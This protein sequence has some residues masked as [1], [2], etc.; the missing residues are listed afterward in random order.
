VIESEKILTFEVHLHKAMVRFSFAIR[1]G[2]CR[3]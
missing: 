1:F 2:G 3:I